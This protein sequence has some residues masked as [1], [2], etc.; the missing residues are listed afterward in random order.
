MLRTVLTIIVPMLLAACATFG[1]LNDGLYALVGKD[2]NLAVS[3]L[4]QPSGKRQLEANTVY[5][6]TTSRVAGI[7]RTGFVPGP[8]GPV[9]YIAPATVVQDCLVDLHADSSGKITKAEY[10]GNMTSCND[11]IVRLNQWKNSS[12]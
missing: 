1:D 12:Q 5:T 3:V 6:W 2:I 11:Y 9:G 4:G 8:Q 10:S 7:A